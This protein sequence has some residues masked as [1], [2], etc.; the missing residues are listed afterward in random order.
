MHKLEARL[1]QVKKQLLDYLRTVVL[2]DHLRP[3]V[4]KQTHCLN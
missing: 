3:M 1:Q 2:K 4:L